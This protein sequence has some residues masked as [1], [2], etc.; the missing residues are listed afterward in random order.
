MNIFSRLLCGVALVGLATGC[1]NDELPT[2]S[3]PEKSGDVYARLA[4]SLPSTRSQTTTDG[5]SDAGFEVGKDYENKVTS[6][7]V[8]LAE[9]DGENYNYITSA[10]TDTKGQDAIDGDPDKYTPEKPMYTVTF[11]S[12]AIAEFADQQVYVF[13]FCNPNMNLVNQ[14]GQLKKADKYSLNEL[15]GN[16]NE[17]SISTK[18]GFFMSNHSLSSVKIPKMEELL[19]DYNTPTN[20]FYLGTIDVSRVTA[21]F[22]FRETQFTDQE[23]KNCYPIYDTFTTVIETPKRDEAGNVIKDEKGNIVYDS[24]T[25]TTSNLMGYVTIDGMALMNE[26]L[27]Y[28]CLPRVS[29]NGM[30]SVVSLCGNEN[31]SNFVVSPNY[32][33]KVATLTNQ[34]MLDNYLYTGIPTSDAAA[35]TVSPYNYDLFDFEPL[36][37]DREEDDDDNWNVEEGASKKGYYIWKY[38]TENTI[39]GND[40]DGV[41]ETIA[42]Q[43]LGVT[44]CIV[45]RA[46]ITAVAG[47]AV[48]DQM[49][50]NDYI[51]CFNGQLIGNMKTLKK[52]VKQNPVS[53]LADAFYAAAKA[54]GLTMNE[55]GTIDPDN[56][57]LND[58]Q[59]TGITDRGEGLKIFKPENGKY[60]CYY[61]YRNRHNDNQSSWMMGPMEFA[62]VRNNIY[63]IDVQNILEFGHTKYSKDDPDPEDPNTPDEPNK[64]YFRLQVRVL[65]WVVRVNHAVL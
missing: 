50:G 63:K 7:L 52:E 18:D 34:F 47:S 23:A 32:D 4:L 30:G 13:A 11:E 9:Q 33:Q 6:V 55:D 64:A 8:V 27:S 24:V 16:L 61:I 14:L 35:A 19:H 49:N 57:D 29:A 40:A 20:P 12:S 59:E 42:Y 5:N 46:S 1:S 36:G 45:F 26:A 17:G 54:N 53:S 48:E 41:N 39:P 25:E 58:F 3:A 65:P 2:G 10:L 28:Y 21:R 38:V 37:G 43:K 62:V 15:K 56:V 44:T 31:S 60:Y 51:Y 22:D